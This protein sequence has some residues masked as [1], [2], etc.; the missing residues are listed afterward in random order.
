VPKG[1]TPLI[2]IYTEKLDSNVRLW[3]E[4]QGIG[5][6]KESQSRLFG[7]FQRL[8]PQSAYDGTGIGLSIVRKAAERMGGSVGV[9]SDLGKGSRFWLQL[10]AASEP[11]AS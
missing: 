6:A 9:I 10:R 11:D 2:R 4:D 1:E 5:I 7:L 3:V 8:H